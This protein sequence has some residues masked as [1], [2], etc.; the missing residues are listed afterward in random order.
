LKDA[1]EAD[2]RGWSYQIESNN[3]AGWITNGT[4]GARLAF[5]VRCMMPAGD[6]KPTVRIGYLATYEN[7]GRVNVTFE[8]TQEGL[9]GWCQEKAGY[10]KTYGIDGMWTS[11]VSMTQHLAVEC[12]CWHGYWFKLVIQPNP[13]TPLADGRSN[14]FKINSVLVC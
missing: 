12:P 4:V 9:G 11:R 13:M 6:Y 1:A 2:P 8:N 10:G 5:W 14:K 3:K 7:I